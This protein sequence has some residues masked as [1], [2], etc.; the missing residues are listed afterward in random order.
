[1]NERKNR[2]VAIIP[3][4][5]GSSRFSGKPLAKIHGVPMV[6]HCYFRTRMCPEL[7]E[8]YVA[9]C[10]QEIF[11]YIKSVGGKVVMTSDKHDRATDRTA[12][13]MLKIEDET[14]E[15]FDIVVMVQGDEPMVTPKMI[16]D[17]VKP[18]EGNDEIEDQQLLAEISMRPRHVLTRTK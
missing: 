7:L 5:M 10:D 4:R 3:A 2:I 11:D 1:M 6:G 9:T 14:G 8:T 18:F 12:E 17:A 13:A 15:E 16:S